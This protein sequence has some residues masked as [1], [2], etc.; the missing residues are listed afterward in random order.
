MTHRNRGRRNDWRNM[1]IPEALL[2]MKFGPWGAEFG[3]WDRRGRK[4]GRRGKRMFDSGELRLVLLKLIEEEPR[5]GYDLIRAIEELTDGEYVP[6]AGVIYPTLSLLED[7]GLIAAL[8]SDGNRKAFEITEE[9]KAELEEKA[10]EVDS[11][12]MRLARHGDRGRKSES[13]SVKRAMG[14]LFAVL[15]HRLSERGIDEELVRE[16]TDILDDAAQRI[17]RL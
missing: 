3:N 14:N 5:H 8:E 7:S 11:L 2:A 16:V 10:G 17:E 12:M 13:A 15:G 1:G 6:S 4:H 9:G